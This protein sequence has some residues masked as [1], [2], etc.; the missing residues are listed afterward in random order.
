MRPQDFFELLRKR[1]FAPFRIYATDGRTYDVRHPDQALVLKTRVILPLP[2]SS[3][4]VSERSEH[5]ALVHVVRLE[6][7]SS[8]ASPSTTSAAEPT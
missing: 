3:G 4:D 6:E 1:P 8:D 2:P 7:F 5:L